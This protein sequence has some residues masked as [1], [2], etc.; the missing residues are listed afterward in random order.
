[1]P[2][3]KEDSKDAS[4]LD[5]SNVKASVVATDMHVVEPARPAG[6]VYVCYAC[7]RPIGP[8]PGSRPPAQNAR[9]GKFPDWVIATIIIVV[10]LVVCF[11]AI[12]W[13][14][15]SFTNSIKPSESKND[16]TYNLQIASGNYTYFSFYSTQKIDIK[17]TATNSMKFD[18]YLMDYDAY[19]QSYVA[20][21]SFNSF[22]TIHSSENINSVS[23]TITMPSG[24]S[25]YYLIFDNI[26]NP[27]SSNDASPTGTLRISLTI[28][29]YTTSIF[30]D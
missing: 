16:Y 18:M 3:A 17:A 14:V 19:R 2:D 7:N 29:R 4:S 9:K 23:T 22:T 13:A 11:S 20:N 27:L 28:T 8:Q 10:V 24:G 5:S 15:A 12:A 1:M 30:N 21:R 6:P 26:D 25:S